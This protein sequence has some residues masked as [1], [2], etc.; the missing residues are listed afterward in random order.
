[1]DFDKEFSRKPRPFGLNAIDGAAWL[2]SAYG[3]GVGWQGEFLLLCDDLLKRCSSWYEDYDL[4]SNPAFSMKLTRF[5]EICATLANSKTKAAS[6]S[7]RPEWKGFLD[8]RL[9]D[10]QLGELDAWQINAGELFAAVDG[11]LYAGFRLTVSY[12]SVTK[13]ANCTIID[14]RSS[15][16]SA[17][18]GLST[19]DTSSALALKAAVFKHSVVLHGDWAVL[20]DKPSVGGRRG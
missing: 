9:D 2:S 20:M 4:F 1:M 12:N 16:P 13:L 19:A 8:F 5:R 7:V 17:G 18:F 11:I 3:E 14:D 15:S 6:K 10:E